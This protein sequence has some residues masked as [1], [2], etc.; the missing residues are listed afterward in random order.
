MCETAAIKSDDDDDRRR[1]GDRFLRRP[2]EQEEGIIHATTR[3]IMIERESKLPLII[4]L[5]IRACVRVKRACIYYI[6]R[7]PPPSVIINYDDN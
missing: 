1:D 5:D 3:E 7:T 6:L 2:E 4:L